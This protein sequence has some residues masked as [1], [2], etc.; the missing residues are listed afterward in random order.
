MQKTRPQKRDLEVME[1]LVVSEILGFG[2][3]GRVERG[4]IGNKAWDKVLGFTNET[5]LSRPRKTS[6]TG[7]RKTR[8]CV[9]GKARR[10]EF[11]TKSSWAV[12]LCQ[13]K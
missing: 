5:R 3:H 6:R 13:G 4:E 11:K 8:E 9:V 12:R 10:S 1:T 2:P 7:R